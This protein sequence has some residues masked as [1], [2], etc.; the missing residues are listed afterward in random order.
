MAALRQPGLKERSLALL[1]TLDAANRQL[2]LTA[3]SSKKYLLARY[4]ENTWNRG[5]LAEID[6][7]W[8]ELLARAAEMWR[9][10]GNTELAEKFAKAA[11]KADPGGAIKREK[12]AKASQGP[13][14][15]TETK[16]L[17]LKKGNWRIS[18]SLENT[19]LAD[20][21]VF[22]LRFSSAGSKDIL[23]DWR[24]ELPPGQAEEHGYISLG[25]LQEGG[26]TF[27]VEASHMAWKVDV[28]PA[29]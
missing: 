4:P 14:P 24:K 7:W 28:Q 26:Y 13:G 29:Q 11:Q 3:L 2:L 15:L 21:G 5:M 23:E 27:T 16:A 25:E 9:R 18:W 1:A 22:E 17:N 10:K 20:N 8:P 19:S 6:A 12:P